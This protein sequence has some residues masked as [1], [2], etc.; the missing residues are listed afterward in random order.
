MPIDY[1]KYPPNWKTEIRPRILERDGNKCKFCHVPN[2]MLI[3]RDNRYG[4]RKDLW[5]GEVYDDKTGELRHDVSWRLSDWASDHAC[6]IVLTI[7]HLD[8]NVE[9]NED[10]NLAALCQRCHLHH[11]RD[12]HKESRKANREKGQTKLF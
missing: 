11:D 8:H 12:Q 1:K 7:A 2:K 4:I 9:N 6:R 3:S 5:N 10:E